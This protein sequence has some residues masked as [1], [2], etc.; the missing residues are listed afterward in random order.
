MMLALRRNRGA[1]TTAVG[2]G[3]TLFTR[4]GTPAMTSRNCFGGQT[5]LRRP[6]P[7]FEGGQSPT[8][9]TKRGTLAMTSK[10]CS[11]GDSS[12]NGPRYIFSAL[13]SSIVGAIC[14]HM[15]Q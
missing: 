2:S 15:D 14:T 4:R 7:L 5:N 9:L 6:A 8:L 3:P 1:A 12:A 13:A 11:G 10:N